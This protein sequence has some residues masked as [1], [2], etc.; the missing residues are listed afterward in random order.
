MSGWTDQ[1]FVA[2]GNA[3][4]WP[5]L[6]ALRKNSV[7]DFHVQVAILQNGFPGDLVLSWEVNGKAQVCR[8]SS[9]HLQGSVVVQLFKENTP[10]VSTYTVYMKFLVKSY[11]KHAKYSRM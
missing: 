9:L 5:F 1:I 6:W 11:T 3:F 10:T 7:G 4:H 2:D 8:S